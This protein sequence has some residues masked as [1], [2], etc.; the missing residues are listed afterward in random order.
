MS[1]IFAPGPP[2]LDQWTRTEADAAAAYAGVLRASLAPTVAAGL[3]LILDDHRQVLAMLQ[4]LDPSGPVAPPAG[5]PFP[6]SLWAAA[7]AS[8]LD[9]REALA[10]L[11]AAE[12]ACIEAYDA[13][14]ADPLLPV[15]ARSLLVSVIR[16]RGRQHP[17][18]LARLLEASHP[19]P[20]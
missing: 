5:N 6:T 9:V 18:Q 14:A 1:T 19:D 11:L 17:E 7:L 20:A 12:R 13:Q 4:S 3:R 16:P 10:A 8:S 15:R 2:W